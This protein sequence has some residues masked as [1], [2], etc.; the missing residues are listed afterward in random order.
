MMTTFAEELFEAED[1]LDWLEDKMGEL[2]DKV[3]GEKT[4]ADFT[5]DP[6]DTSIEV[7]FDRKLPSELIIRLVETMH[8][9]GFKLVW[10]HFHDRQPVS[11]G[12][13]ACRPEA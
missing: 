6:A 8:E 7:Y 9:A 3:C 12:R 4:W 13:C 5:Y 10:L 2:L 11:R 1:H